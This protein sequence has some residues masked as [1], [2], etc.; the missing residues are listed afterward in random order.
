MDDLLCY[1]RTPG[2][3]LITKLDLEFDVMKDIC[4][5]FNKR[6]V[7]LSQPMFKPLTTKGRTESSPIQRSAAT[8][9]QA[10]TCQ[11]RFKRINA[12]RGKPNERSDAK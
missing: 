9:S 3:D 4:P 11:V 6:S 12:Q 8:T 7:T 2:V 10:T 5:S 1:V